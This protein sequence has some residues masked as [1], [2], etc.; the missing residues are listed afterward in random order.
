MA[1]NMFLLQIHPYWIIDEEHLSAAKSSIVF[2]CVEL[3]GDIESRGPQELGSNAAGSE[4]LELG[5]ISGEIITSY[6]RIP[7]L[8]QQLF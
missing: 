3:T 6:N 7:S 4:I 5:L 2:S 1:K 8:N